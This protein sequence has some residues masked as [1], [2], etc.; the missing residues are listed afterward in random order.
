MRFQDSI[1]LVARVIPHEFIG[2][3]SSLHF[4]P[5]ITNLFLPRETLEVFNTLLQQWT[6]GNLILDY[7][8]TDPYEAYLIT[9]IIVAGIQFVGVV[10]IT[11]IYNLPIRDANDCVEFLQ[12][13]TFWLKN[14]VESQEESRLGMAFFMSKISGHGLSPYPLLFWIVVDSC[15]VGDSLRLKPADVCGSYEHNSLTFRMMLTSK[16]Y[17][18][19]L[20][21]DCMHMFVL[22]EC[23]TPNDPETSWRISCPSLP[24]TSYDWVQ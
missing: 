14:H 8:T 13:F 15:T 6:F 17:V 24:S 22:L 5:L 9:T 3:Y 1:S 16:P 4:L 11:K 21:N 18:D 19:H 10:V 2:T 20:G 12:G 7:H 23:H